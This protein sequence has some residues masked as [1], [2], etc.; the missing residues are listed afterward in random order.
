MSLPLI[1]SSGDLIADRRYEWA[2]ELADRGDRQAAAE[3]LAQALELVPGFAAAWFGLG[4]L[5]EAAG[6][7]G[8]AIAAFRRAREADPEDRHGAGLR[9]VRLGVDAGAEPMSPGYVR[10]LFDQYAT[11][12]D[13][14]LV[15]GLAYRAPQILRDA[16]QNTC[17]PDRRFRRLIDLGCGTGLAGEAF[18]S[19][20]ATM[21]GVDLSPVMIEVA[22]RKGIYDQLVVGDMTDWLGREG[23]PAD[24]VVAA[25]AFVY[26]ADLAAV[27]RAIAGVLA[28]DGLVA[29]TV[30][31]HPGDDVMLGEKLRYAH[32]ARHLRAAV[33][34]AGLT[35]KVCAAASPRADNGVPVPGLVVVAGTAS[36]GP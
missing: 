11:R 28:P 18:C 22:R 2:R 23:C 30:E 29:F 8:G 35:L 10:A 15:G 31:T 32:G 3:L 20:C 14:A 17:G 24:L 27:C 34:A 33:A 36:R 4:D 13:A 26:L 5:R 6:D 16:V 7:Q 12:F 19:R 25:D 9:L 1:S 21:V